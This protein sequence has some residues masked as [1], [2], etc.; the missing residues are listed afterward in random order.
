LDCYSLRKVKS[1][2]NGFVSPSCA[3]K[4]KTREA[5]FSGLT[6]EINEWGRA[7]TQNKQHLKDFLASSNL[8]LWELVKSQLATALFE[9]LYFIKLLRCMLLELSPDI[10]VIPP[11]PH[12]ITLCNLTEIN[13]KT[14]INLADTLGIK[15]LS[16]PSL[17]SWFFYLPY[18]LIKRIPE[19]LLFFLSKIRVNRIIRAPLFRESK[20]AQKDNIDAKRGKVIFFGEFPNFTFRGAIPVLLELQDRGFDCKVAISKDNSRIHSNI[21]GIGI[22]STEN[23]EKGIDGNIL[24]TI[25]QEYKK[26]WLILVRENKRKRFFSYRGISLLDNEYQDIARFLHPKAV[27]NIFKDHEVTKCILETERP[28]CLIFPDTQNIIGKICANAAI[29]KGIPYLCLPEV[30]DQLYENT[31]VFDIRKNSRYAVVGKGVLK[32]AGRGRAILSENN[33]VI[34]GSAQWDPYY[35]FLPAYDREYIYDKLN[36]DKKNSFFIFTLQSGLP[37]NEEVIKALMRAMKYFPDKYLIIRPHPNDMGYYSSYLKHN[38]KGNVI[39]SK[40]F[41]FASIAA[42]SELI[43]TVYSLTGFEAMLL[44]KPVITINFSFY[45]DFMP[46]VRY[47]AALK[48]EKEENLVDT[49]ERAIYD[50]EG[51][52]KLKEGREIIIEDYAYKVDGMSAE[53]IANEA[54]LLVTYK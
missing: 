20:R 49:I 29:E 24:S 52:R 47:G 53:R 30:M 12:K 38:M 25:Y 45:P 27:R 23:Y 44:D 17:I 4:E 19:I 31:F 46:Y 13:R 6:R 1:K 21:R 2:G 22:I 26:K 37:E 40:D 9:K 8:D 16:S 35:K 33:A 51:R 41:D 32:E 11:F 50:R 34:T 54:E 10:L 3:L 18:L 48:V 42:A 36:I 43:L 7:E 5:I 28:D 14:I 15:V 39:F